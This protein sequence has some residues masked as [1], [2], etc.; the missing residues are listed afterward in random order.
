MNEKAHNKKEYGWMNSLDESQELLFNSF[1]EI[2][3]LLKAI[4]H[5]NRFKIL[6][7]LLKG[8]M[9]FQGLLNEM[10]V[11]KSA[12]ANHLNHLK[13]KSLVEKIQHG[14]YKITDDGRDFVKAIEAAYRGSKARKKKIEEARQRQELTRSFLERK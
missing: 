1:D 7:L 2:V 6:I 3:A 12:L 5:S 4:G 14:T 10:N 8:P 11:K 9:T 13:N